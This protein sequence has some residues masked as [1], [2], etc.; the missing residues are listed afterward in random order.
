MFFGSV[1]IRKPT[2]FIMGIVRIGESIDLGYRS[3]VSR[4]EP[5]LYYLHYSL[6][7]MSDQYQNIFC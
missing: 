2:F 5:L 7:S 1:N 6:K 3:P 4:Y